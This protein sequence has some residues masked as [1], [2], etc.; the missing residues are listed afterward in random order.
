MFHCSGCDEGATSYSRNST[1]FS[2]ALGSLLLAIAGM[3]F[4]WFIVRA[5]RNKIKSQ[6][7][8]SD[9]F[10]SMQKKNDIIEIIHERFKLN[11]RDDVMK[12]FDFLDQDGDGVL[13][14]TELG[15]ELCLAENELSTF[16]LKMNRAAGKDNANEQ[17]SRD[18][19]IERF[20]ETIQSVSNFHPTTS[21]ALDL[22]DRIAVLHN[23]N[24]DV[25]SDRIMLSHLLDSSLS[26]FLSE[27]QIVRLIRHFRAGLKKSRSEPE[28]NTAN[29]EDEEEERIHGCNPQE[30]SARTKVRALPSALQL[31]ERARSGSTRDVSITRKEFVLHYPDLV[32]KVMGERED[33][34]DE[35]L[36]QFD[37]YFEGLSLHTPTKGILEKF[38]PLIHFDYKGHSLDFP[39]AVEQ[40]AV[41]IDVTGR[42]ENG[43]MTALMGKYDVLILRNSILVLVFIQMFH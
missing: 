6:K 41:I 1:G 13:S 22:F 12:L 14:K 11:C 23:R 15:K 4:R 24:L 37:V 2:F 38:F 21:D 33:E 16:I 17:V 8:N 18:C 36:E 19:F 25:V 40:K 29:D 34:R 30:G 7:G 42:I 32:L 43:K 20:F 9:A 26:D 39:P 27:K 10:G 3:V 35:K 31:V 5:R 28:I